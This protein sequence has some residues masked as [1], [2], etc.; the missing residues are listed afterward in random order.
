VTSVED[1]TL[2][3]TPGNLTLGPVKPTANGSFILKFPNSHLEA[4]F[5]AFAKQYTQTD[6]DG[7]PITTA[8][9]FAT[10]LNGVDTAS[11]I[12]FSASS[13]KGSAM[14]KHHRHNRRAKHAKRHGNRYEVSPMKWA[15]KSNS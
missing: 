15:S 9:T 13:G 2:L 7:N 4:V 6:D 14:H 12:T 3:T 5:L 1:S 11:Q 8:P 10:L